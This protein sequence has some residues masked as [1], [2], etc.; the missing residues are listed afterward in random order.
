MTTKHFMVCVGLVWATT[1]ISIPAQGS[2]VPLFHNGFNQIEDNDW[3]TFILDQDSDGII[4]VGDRFVGVLQVQTI[5]GT[6]VGAAGNPTVTAVFAVELLSK[7]GAD[8]SATQLNFG[9][10][11][12]GGV[13]A[14]IAQWAALGLNLPALTSNATTII[15]FDFP[16]YAI[17]NSNTG[18][19]S[20]S[21]DTFDDTVAGTATL[22]EFGF[23]GDAGEFWRTIGNAGID[24]VV[25]LI[26]PPFNP[27]GARNE[28][29]VNVTADN[30]ADSV[31][32][33][34]HTALYPVA[35]ALQ[36]TGTF[37]PP[38]LQPIGDFGISTDT[39]FVVN[40][41]VVPEPVSVATWGV[42]TLIVGLAAWRARTKSR[43]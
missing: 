36:G 27:T 6:G 31:T 24:N 5:N 30:P 14:A 4:D 13:D 41:N 40:L 43:D 33:N 12:S 28:I 20:G 21:I 32:F 19:L 11:Q 2:V 25:T 18:T 26:G 35:T 29:S 22:A 38:A 9:P 37:V 10:L 1:L 3:E 23:L 17:S 34:K 15:T 7:V 39:D 42:L 16:D 8:G